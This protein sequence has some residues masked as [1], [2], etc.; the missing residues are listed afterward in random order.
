[1]RTKRQHQT[2]ASKKCTLRVHKENQAGDCQPHTHRGG[3]GPNKGNRP[4]GTPPRSVSP[5]RGPQNSQMT[6]D[7]HSGQKR[8]RVRRKP[9]TK[10]NPGNKQ[11]Q[12]NNRIPM[13]EEAGK[14]ARLRNNA[15]EE[16]SRCEDNNTKAEP[17]ARKTTTKGVAPT[18]K[19]PKG[20][21]RKKLS[22][23]RLQAE[24]GGKTPS[25]KIH[26]CRKDYVESNRTNSREGT[27]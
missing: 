16:R 27:G 4:R 25:P 13:G 11:A 8:T 12:E 2:P 23:P 1:M 21:K 10:R 17:A 19:H 24:T 15:G 14:T 9:M 26:S 20:G 22:R 18:G 7:H 6:R 3:A 5:Y